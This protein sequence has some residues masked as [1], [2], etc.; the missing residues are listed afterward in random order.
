MDKRHSPKSSPSLTACRLATETWRADS[1]CVRQ[2]VCVGGEGWRR[3][4][5]RRT[6]QGGRK[7]PRK[8]ERERR[9][10]WDARRAVGVAWLASIDVFV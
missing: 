8:A 9:G 3:G 6:E 5:E 2:C 7:T 10:R 4:A 1:R